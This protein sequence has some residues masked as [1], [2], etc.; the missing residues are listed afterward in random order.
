MASG[1]EG[2]GWRRSLSLSTDQFNLLLVL[3][4]KHLHRLRDE[5][6]RLEMILRGRENPTDR[7][8]Y[9]RACYQLERTTKLIQTLWESRIHDTLP[10]ARQTGDPSGQG[11][12]PGSN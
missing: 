5:V 4:H 10:N 11:G 1:N 8:L 3:T 2:S 9:A 12:P 6:G 7:L